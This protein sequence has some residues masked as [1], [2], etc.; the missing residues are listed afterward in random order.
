MK[1]RN[2]Q[3]KLIIFSAPSASGKTSIVRQLMTYPEL[4]LAFSVSATSRAKRPGEQDGVHYYFLTPEEFRQRIDEE[5]FIEW[6]EVY[7]DHFYGTLKSEVERL[8]AE[9]KNVI[10]DIDVKGGMNIKRM[11]PQKTLSVFVAVPRLDELEKRLRYRNTESEDKI[12][13]RLAKAREEMQYSPY[14]D[15][16]LVNDDLEKSVRE[17]YGLVKSF[18][19]G[20]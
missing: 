8:L 20:K 18:I 10:F 2:K 9:G 1:N 7:P 19:D 4:N 12:R 17:A 3:G 13:L 16:I 6:E 15:V 14:F 11:Y 5:A